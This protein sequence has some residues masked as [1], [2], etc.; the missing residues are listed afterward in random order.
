MLRAVAVGW[1]FFKY[2]HIHLLKLHTENLSRVDT[3][4]RSNMGLSLI[5][6]QKQNIKKY[7]TII[8]RQKL[9]GLCFFSVEGNKPFSFF[10]PTLS[11]V[12]YEGWNFNSGNYLF[13]TDTK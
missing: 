9:Q 8:Y 3:V 6:S 4:C 1:F 10:L 11:N 7:L 5:P 12:I 2:C 13:T